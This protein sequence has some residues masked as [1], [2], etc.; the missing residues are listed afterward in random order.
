V[1]VES[2]MMSPD[3]VGGWFRDDRD[4]VYTTEAHGATVNA[5]IRLQ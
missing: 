2:L 4:A 3:G 5:R 1:L